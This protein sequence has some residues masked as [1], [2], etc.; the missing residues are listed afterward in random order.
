MRVLIAF[1]AIALMAVMSFVT[2]PAF[3]AK[4]CDEYCLGVC[5][6]AASKSWS[7]EPISKLP[8]GLDQL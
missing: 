1:S 2:V 3:A 5:Q 6:T 4:S 8:T 7:L